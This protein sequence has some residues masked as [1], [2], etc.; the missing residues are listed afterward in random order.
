MEFENTKEAITLEDL[1]KF[2]S[3]YKVLLPESYKIHLLKYNGGFP[4]LEMY[5]GKFNIPIDSFLPLKYGAQTIEK[6]IKSLEN[7]L[8][9]GEIPFARTTSG[10]IFMSL[11][12]ENYGFIY[13]AYSDWEPNLITNSFE[14]FMKG[15]HENEIWN[16]K[17]KNNSLRV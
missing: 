14:D 4:V 16:R 9:K 10:T 7:V 11:R 12:E 2:E 6:A 5:F 3:E 15:M 17:W 8:N 13:V 1:N